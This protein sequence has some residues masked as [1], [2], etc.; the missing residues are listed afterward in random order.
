MHCLATNVAVWVR[1]LI[2]ESLK[3]ING[4]H[5][6]DESKSASPLKATTVSDAFLRH[7]V[8]A[9]AGDE[10]GGTSSSHESSM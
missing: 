10:N 2:R 9:V 4:H 5:P 6:H 1:T 7:M 8:E 3:E